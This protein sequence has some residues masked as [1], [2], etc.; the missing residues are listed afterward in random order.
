MVNFPQFPRTSPASFTGPVLSRSIFNRKENF[1]F[2]LT[3]DVNSPADPSPEVADTTFH[4]IVRITEQFCLR[5]EEKRL[6]AGTRSVRQS[7]SVEV[8]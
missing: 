6:P 5:F 2:D 7:E 3:Q 8:A 1:M 4:R